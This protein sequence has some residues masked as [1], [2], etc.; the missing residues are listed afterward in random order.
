[1]LGQVPITITGDSMGA[2]KSQFIP[3]LPL[4]PISQLP[5]LRGTGFLREGYMQRLGSQTGLESQL[6]HFLV[7]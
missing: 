4:P 6:H 2:L 7:L 1:M 3:T 5:T